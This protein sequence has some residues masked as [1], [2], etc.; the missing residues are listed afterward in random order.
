MGHPRGPL[1]AYLWYLASSTSVCHF[2]PLTTGGQGPPNKAPATSSWDALSE[3]TPVCAVAGP[4]LAD[5]PDK[6]GV[7]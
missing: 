2:S 3:Q 6:E 7:L 4:A 1:P 5:S